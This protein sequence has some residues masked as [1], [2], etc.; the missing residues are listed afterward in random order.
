MNI[1]LLG[2]GGQLGRQL[3]RS[4]A[5]LGTLTALT[6][7]GRPATAAHPALCGDL[8]QPSALAQTLS[9]LR[10]DVVVNA[11][12]Y[13]NVDHAEIN[14]Q[15]AHAVNARGCEA[16]ASAV[17]ELGAHL[18]HFSTDYVFDGAGEKPWQESDLCRP[19]NAYGRSKLAGEQAIAAACSRYWIFRT[20]WLYELASTNFLT[21]VLDAAQRGERLQIV[22]DQWG[23]PTRAAWVADTLAQVLQP[24]ERGPARQQAAASGIY[25]LAAAGHTDW[26]AYAQYALQE[27]SAC[28]AQL[29]TTVQQVQAIA[30]AARGGTVRPV[31]SRLDTALLQTTFG[32]TPPP[33][34]D[35]VRRV[36]AQWARAQA[37]GQVQTPM[38]TQAQAQT[39]LHTPVQ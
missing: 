37:Q 39:Q 16:L 20:S 10:P 1:V 9:H 5:A 13:T 32:I 36:V 23:A 38:Q 21:T 28:G 3:A 29:K 31:N 30:A 12:A 2:A 6:R 33:W 4:L 11:A 19:L 34:Q 14:P 15:A 26:Y 8:C 25:H 35:G 27:A 18:V 17:Q 7:T 24:P 22:C